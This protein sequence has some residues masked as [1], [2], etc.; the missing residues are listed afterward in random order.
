MARVESLARLCRGAKVRGRKNLVK[1]T[2]PGEGGAVNT[3]RCRLERAK[4]EA[5]AGNPISC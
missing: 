3:A 1:F 4:H 5:G 2:T